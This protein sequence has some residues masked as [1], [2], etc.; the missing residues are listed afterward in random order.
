MT[1]EEFKTQ[2][3]DAF[4]VNGWDFHSIASWHMASWYGRDNEDEIHTID[5]HSS[6]DGFSIEFHR[7]KD[8]LTINRC[9]DLRGIVGGIPLSM[10][11]MKASASALI[12]L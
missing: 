5:V 12:K 8:R 11:K 9:G 1:F 10:D 2:V 3:L 4:S 6:G 7:G